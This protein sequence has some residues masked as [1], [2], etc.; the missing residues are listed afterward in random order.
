MIVIDSRMYRSSGI[1]TYIRNLIPYVLEGMP[2][3]RFALI[4]NL[5]EVVNIA[6]SFGERVGF[7]QC[8]VPLYSVSEQIRLIT[9]LPAETKLFWS[10]HYNIPLFYRGKLLVTVHDVLHLAMPQFVY[11]FIKRLYSQYMFAAL[12]QK[13]SEILCVSSF[14]QDELYRLVRVDRNK[15]SVIHIGV[16][17]F[18]FNKNEAESPH[19][20]P[21]ILYVGN[22]KPHKNLSRLI[23]A[24]ELIKDDNS[25]D[26][27]IVG[28]KEGFIINDEL[29]VKQ[30]I[31][32]CDRVRFTGMI[33]DCALINYYACAQ[34]LVLPSLYEGFGL[35]PIEAM[36][37]G[38]PVIV[39][40]I[41]SLPE[42]C[43]D[44]AVYFDPYSPRDIADKINL[45]LN[46]C[47]LREK[48]RLKGLERAKI[49]TWEKCA[50]QTIAVINRMLA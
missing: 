25:V 30:A 42:V 5:T 18:W 34:A 48:M 28:K 36:A 46:D 38:C 6:D 7:I 12:K 23:E 4:G 35:P 3:E 21:Y 14:T 26:L 45:V 2:D 13:A 10:P 29:A 40:D 15:T 9:S 20:R 39:S 24:F 37:C 43:G 11:G 50:E 1:G 19:H 32:L 16:S 22:V 27:V 41:A 33:D 8:D 44:A 49:F 31:K 17:E 47:E